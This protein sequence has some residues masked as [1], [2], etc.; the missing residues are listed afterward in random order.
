MTSLNDNKAEG[1]LPSVAIPSRTLGS[2]RGGRPRKTNHMTRTGASL[3][4][5]FAAASD[6]FPFPDRLTAAQRTRA[7]EVVRAFQRWVQEGSTVADLGTGMAFVP[8]VLS[9]FGY[10]AIGVDDYGDPWH[11]RNVVDD[12]R[13]YAKGRFDLRCERIEEFEPSQLLDGASLIDVIEH[14]HDSPRALLGHVARILRPGAICI[15]VM[16]NSVN[17]RKRVDVVRGLTPYPRLEDFFDADP[18]WRGHVREYTPSETGRLLTLAGF[19]L[20]QVR[21]FHSIAL[22]RLRGVSLAAYRAVTALVPNARDTI[23]AVGR[24]SNDARFRPEMATG[25]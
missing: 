2:R 7:E 11:D 21:T 18:P 14:L 19:E 12:L 24:S 15:V 23:L 6:G 9:E 13:N 8:S 17:L 16:P 25:Q 3:A 1:S 10:R 4:S 20:V 5:A 22:D